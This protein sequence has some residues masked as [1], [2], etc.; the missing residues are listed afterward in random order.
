MILFKGLFNNSNPKEKTNEP[1]FQ[2]FVMVNYYEE[3]KTKAQSHSGTET[4]LKTCI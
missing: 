4:G 2:E 1:S 3:G